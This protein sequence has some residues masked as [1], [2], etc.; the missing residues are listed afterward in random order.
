MSHM[1]T[2]RYLGLEHGWP[3]FELSGLQI[4]DEGELSLARV[5]SLT[6]TLADPIPPV[7]GLDGP[8][9][10]GV[11][12]CGNLYVADPAKHI[13]IRIDGCDGSSAPFGCMTRRGSEPGQLDAPRGVLV[14]PRGALYVADSG[15]RRVQIFDLAT[16]QLRGMLGDPSGDASTS[17]LPGHFTQP[18]DLAADSRG[19]VYV[20][21]PGVL[22]A[23]GR[24]S[25]GRVQKF[26]PGGTVDPTFATT[27]AAQSRALGAPASIAVALLD[28]TRDD[29]ERLLVLDRQP[30]QILVY[31]LDGTLD[32]DA[33]ARWA[34]AVGAGSAPVSIV[35]GGGALYVA[36]GATGRVALFDSAGQFLGTAASDDG[37][38]A[39]GIALDCHGRLVV[40]PGSGGSV[41]RS[42]GLPTYAEC[43]TWLAGP[44]DAQTDPTRWQRIQLEIDT[45]PDSTHL[46]VYTLTSNVLDGAPANR[47]VAPA[48][49]GALSSAVVVAAD[50]PVAAPL[51]QWRAAPWD[52][53]DL[54]ALN[55]P[56]Q[57][58]WIA[59]I[60]QGDGSGT[61][62]IR[63]IRLTHD[64]DG[65]LPLLPAIYTRNETS[66][67]FLTRALAAFESAM[68][69]E[70]RLIDDLPLLFDADAAADVAP[71]PTWLDW[72]AQWMDAELEESWDDPTR[73]RVVADSFRMHARRGTKEG[74][75]R[76][77]ALHAGTTP[78]IT[79]TA[80]AGG[81]WALGVTALGLDSALAS[82][83]PD[84]AVLGTTAIVDHSHLI[85]E[86]HR[87]APAFDDVAHHFVVQVYASEA[88]GADGLARVRAVLDREK[89]AH[90]TY[91]LC[92]IEPRMRVGCQA[93]LG[94]DAVVG[95]PPRAAPLGDGWTLGEDAVLSDAKARGRTGGVIGENA[96][97]G[98][99]ATLS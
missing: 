97:V 83:S 20:A 89:P 92:P 11:D 55:A 12:D 84:G 61:P 67:V 19:N 53:P 56:A 47:P 27:V 23:D 51:E 73:R 24:W 80:A 66:R 6:D 48:A 43:G 38:L 62:I 40:H 81:L 1:P 78:F 86:E 45:L 5:P 3:R 26:R 98:I 75:R 32:L 71:R 15:N 50:D 70:S 14:G 41:Q 21:D 96:R 60:M 46:R 88:R 49:C 95:G 52:A 87:G 69:V 31:A 42:L 91:H 85:G 9:G 25:G 59:G 65:W 99:R 76:L 37:T 94:I 58:L 22:G 30:A 57:F 17:A 39:A 44:F 54:L 16:G 74:L 68:D 2:F 10:V 33:T 29:S 35:H 4:G 18:W 79:E 64:E 82:A 13:I 28:A 93:R 7:P 8:L 63:E 72:L 36:D 34:Q 90:T 77:V